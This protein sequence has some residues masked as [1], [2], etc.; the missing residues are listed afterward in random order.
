MDFHMLFWLPRA[1][2]PPLAQPD[3]NFETHLKSQLCQTTHPSLWFIC[4]ASVF[5]VAT[6]HYSN[7]MNRWKIWVTSLSFV[8]P[9]PQTHASIIA[10]SRYIVIVG[11]LV[12]LPTGL[13][14][15]WMGLCLSSLHPPQRSW[16]HIWQMNGWPIPTS[17]PCKTCC[18]APR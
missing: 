12:C 15:P 11:V 10:V 2:F 16:T 17:L 3:S 6:L 18:L 7:W 5:V 4:L 9:G 1:L 8:L 14:V 13:W